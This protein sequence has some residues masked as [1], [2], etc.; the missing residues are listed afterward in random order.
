VLEIGM[1]ALTK[2]EPPRPAER[3]K[4]TIKKLVDTALRAKVVQDVTKVAR[5]IV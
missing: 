4:K 2:T 3:R 5:A 1:A